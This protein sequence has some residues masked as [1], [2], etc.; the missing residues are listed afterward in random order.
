[1]QRSTLMRN[2]IILVLC[3]LAFTAFFTTIAF[4]F[5]GRSATHNELIDDAFN[6]GS[7]ITAMLSE[8]PEL[9]K[10]TDFLNNLFNSSLVN[11]NS[12]ILIDAQS[13]EI[14]ASSKAL[15]TNERMLADVMNII[16][17]ELVIEGDLQ[18]WIDKL[19][20]S[21]SNTLVLRDIVEIS[22]DEIYYV[23]VVSSIIATDDTVSSFTNILLLSTLLS[24]FVMMIPVFILIRSIV[25]PIYELNNVAR[26]FAQGNLSTRAKES[27]SGEVGELATSFNYLANQLEKSIIDLT[28]ERNRLKDIFDIISEGIVVVDSELKPIFVN[29]AI[30]TIF[31]KVQKRNLF[32]EK[33]QLIPFEEVWD[34]YAVCTTT[35]EVQENTIDGPN[36]AYTYTIVPKFDID[37]ETIIGA[38]GFF[39]DISEEQ[40]LERTRKDYVAN[41]SHELRTPLQ[42][43]RGLIEPL[44]DGMV[45]KEEDRMRYYNIILHETMRLSRLIDDMLELSKLQSRTLAFKTFPFDLNQ[46]LLGIETKYKPVMADADLNFKVLFNSGE[47]PTVLGNP[48]RVE[49]ILVI[50]MDNAKKY[51]PA[52]GSITISTEF[53]EAENKVFISVID[54]GQGIHEY[55]INHI[56]D[57]FFKADRARGK[58]GTGLG[59]SIAK[60]LLTYMGETI[61]VESEYG[62]GT[63]FTFTLK[64]V[65]ATS[66]WY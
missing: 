13:Q 53:N 36:Y 25:R 2:T 29:K 44:A 43:L 10:D 66:N 46:L 40:K 8:S 15:S 58:K 47:L 64:K 41:I 9:A 49:Q 5:A 4:A 23:I 45:K 56:F 61:T 19:V 17:N 51:T 21:E 30:D 52:G 11:N 24:A 28:I 38:T 20:D 3:A 31:D 18:Y 48:D 22:E 60:E 39:R 33:L 1:M 32:T 59:L 14:I 27:S 50:L 7:S 35:K 34:M 6:T 63:T 54:T 42:T 26:K 55:D 62:R 65:V 57:R 12:V 37:N 16:Q